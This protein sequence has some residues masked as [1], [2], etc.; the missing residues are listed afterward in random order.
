MKNF[1]LKKIPLY[2][3]IPVLVILLLTSVQWYK[4]ASVP[5]ETEV[6]KS[7]TTCYNSVRMI[8]ENNNDLVS[9]LLLADAHFESEFLYPLKQSL[10]SVTNQLKNSGI[11][12]EASVY[13]RLLD[14]GEW[15]SVN[16]EVEYQP[17]SIIKL[18]AAITL[19]K[20]A[21]TNKGLLNKKINFQNKASNVPNQTFA[22][23]QLPAGRQ[24]TLH[25]L[26]EYMII[27]S[28]NQ[29]TELINRELDKTLYVKLYEDLELPVPD[30]KSK[31]YPLNCIQLSKFIRVIYNASYLSKENS[32]LLL[33]LLSKSTFHSG[34]RSSVAEGITV[35]SK[36]G[37]T[38]GLHEAQLHETAI[39]FTR[40]PYVI[41]IDTKG[42][43]LKELPSA[44]YA[45]SNQAFGFFNHL[46]GL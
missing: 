44:I 19:L 24:Y 11:V 15:T 3:I 22:E 8:R 39:V 12:T 23:N 4:S 42:T 37:E 40:R 25:E 2:A 10:L 38:G 14:D 18:A 35:A 33:Q 5:T 9:P 29:A 41:T 20:M 7:N 34:I 30:L 32:E 1:F 46:A 16:P 21:E 26:L 43:N 28:D 27:H 13:V 31:R 45:I 36:F 6:E 17:G